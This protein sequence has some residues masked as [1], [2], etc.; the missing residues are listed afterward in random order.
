M[1]NN[2]LLANDSFSSGSL[3]AGWSAIFGGSV[4][5]VAGAGP[6]FTE[7]GAI[8]VTVY[9]QLWTGL[10]WPSDQ[11]SE[12]TVQALTSSTNNFL[13]LRV[14]YSSAADSGYQAIISNGT[15][16]LFVV[17]TGTPTQL[18]S[19]VSGLTLAAGDVWSFGA[20]GSSVV[21]YQNG[22][23]VAYFG[24]ATY[25]SGS[26]G[27]CQE[28]I[29]VLTQNEV[30][31]WRGYNAI[32]QDG[33]W[34]KQGIVLAPTASDLS[35]SGIGVYE[36]SCIYDSNP[37]ILPGPN[38]YKLWFTVGTNSASGIYYAESADLKT[39]TRHSGAVIAD[40]ATPTVIKQ[41]ST[42]YLY[43]Q[44]GSA[45][46]SGATQISTST[47]GLAWSASGHTFA[48]G[49][50][51][52][53]PIAVVS[54]TWYALW[55]SLGVSDFASVNLATAPDGL[56]WTAYGSN[57]VISSTSTY[58]YPCVAQIGS[59]FYVW[60]QT[61]PSSPQNTATAKAFDPTGCARY[62]TTDFH[63]WTGP[64][65]SIHHSQLFEA[66]NVPVNNAEA[67]GGVA[68]VAIFDISGKANML[69]LLSQGDNIGPQVAQFS[70]A[71]AP[72]LIASVV[73]FN[74]DA[75]QQVASDNF[76]RGSGPIGSNWTVVGAFGT[77]KIVSGNKCEPS[78]ASSTDCFMCYTAASFGAN[79]YSEVTVATFTFAGNLTPIISN[80]AG[81]ALYYVNVN[82]PTGTQAFQA[83]IHYYDGT[84]DI[85]I[86]PSV[87][88]TMQVGDVLRLS[89]VQGAAA[90]VLSFFQNGSL[91]T[92]SVHLNPPAATLYPGAFLLETTAGETQ[93]SL[94]AGGNAN[95]IPN[96]PPIVNSGAWVQAFRG[97]VNKRGVS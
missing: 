33:I 61:G 45:Q 1:A 6:H 31:S 69:Y 50:Y 8:G 52:L 54:G 51:P 25:T 44:L 70:L 76:A 77:F 22:N 32:Q 16:K 96:Y 30:A 85:A 37:Q 89:L 48:T 47:D 40:G 81:T 26:P 9:G 63:T 23:R 67:V 66:V 71:V 59:T 82:T 41:G 92:Q 4:C 75:I 88:M 58:P 29:T 46:G 42:Y 86:S 57:P 15:A 55:G 18:G 78:T 94:W 68:P 60:M 39:W 28:A 3:A 95:V 17:T 90:N 2:Q 12:V 5:Q 93:I 97:F 13:Q 65:R 49:A 64:V 11:I 74:E 80:T 84:T 43:Y 35:G 56:T 87:G 19:T 7:P 21:L 79:P 27:Y 91:V 10:T 53:K 14:R 24:D 83:S 72:S 38:V 62:S 34:Q 36:G 73:Q 20:F